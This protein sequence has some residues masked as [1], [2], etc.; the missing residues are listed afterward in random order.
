MER[1]NNQRQGLIFGQ[2][3]VAYAPSERPKDA[4]FP[5]LYMYAEN[6]GKEQFQVHPKNH[7][8]HLRV[9]VNDVEVAITDDP[10]HV[11]VASTQFWNKKDTDSIYDSELDVTITAPKGFNINSEEL[12]SAIKKLLKARN[13]IDSAVNGEFSDDKL[14]DDGLQ[15]LITVVSKNY[16]PNYTFFEQP[17]TTSVVFAKCRREDMGKI[18][19]DGCQVDD[20]K[21]SFHRFMD[22]HHMWIYLRVLLGYNYPRVTVFNIKNCNTEWTGTPEDDVE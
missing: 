17:G 4:K 8:T 13:I 21:A 15:V 12:A 5:A 10:R 6:H 1:Q 7:R 3:L 20:F 19:G 11:F 18:N 14:E 22:L 2:H 9:F 16:C